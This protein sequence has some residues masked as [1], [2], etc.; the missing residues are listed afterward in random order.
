MKSETWYTLP[1]Q[2]CELL[3]RDEGMLFLRCMSSRPADAVLLVS[4]EDL[5]RIAFIV[6][7]LAKTGWHF[8][9]LV[10]LPYGAKYR[11]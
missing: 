2:L 7:E 11:P 8:S 6:L 4:E 1:S 10:T 5:H 3:F 9:G